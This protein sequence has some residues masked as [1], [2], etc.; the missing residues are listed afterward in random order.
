MPYV[1]PCT[2]GQDAILYKALVVVKTHKLQEE[3]YVKG[4]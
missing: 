4:C 3:K 1:V 2:M